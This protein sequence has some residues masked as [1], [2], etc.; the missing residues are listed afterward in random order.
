MKTEIDPPYKHLV[1]KPYLCAAA[2]V[3]MILPRRGVW[4]E[5]ELVALGLGTRIPRSALNEFHIPL[6]VVEAA[7]EAG[8]GL[9]VFS[10]ENVA[11]FFESNGLNLRLA[12]YHVNDIP[13]VET[14]LLESL[15]KGRDVLVNYSCKLYKPESEEG[16]YS[17]I[18]A[19]DGAVVT[20]CDPWIHNKSFW[21]TTVTDLMRHVDTETYDGSRRGLVLFQ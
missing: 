12:T 7:N 15:S 10:G 13:D 6:P 16:H 17:V 8:T 21:E 20:L 14:F 3:Q 2:S 4:I 11:S 1:Q 18:S 5:Q 9:E 19:I